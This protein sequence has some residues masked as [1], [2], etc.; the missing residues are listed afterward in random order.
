MALIDTNATTETKALY[1]QLQNSQGNYIYFGQD[2]FWEH[3][4]TTNSNNIYNQIESYKITGKVPYLLEITWN[5]ASVNALV[6]AKTH[7]RNGGFI[8]VAWNYANPVT[9]GTSHDKTG[10]PVLNILPGGTHRVN[11]LA[12][13][14]LLA[15]WAG[16]MKD[17]NGNLI[18]FIFRPFQEAD[19]TW[20]WWGEING[21][22]STIDAQYIALW[23]DMVTYLRDTKGVHNIIYDYSPVHYPLPYVFEDR[24]AGDNYIDIISVDAYKDDGEINDVLDYY[25]RAYD[26][27]NTRGKVFGVAEG[28]RKLNDFPLATYWTDYFNGI[29]ADSKVKN[30][31]FVQC[32]RTGITGSQDRWGPLQGST[33][34]ASFLT[35][36]QNPK[37][38][39]LRYED[40]IIDSNNIGINFYVNDDNNSF[41]V[42][43]NTLI[44]NGVDEGIHLGTGF[45]TKTATF[46]N[47]IIK[48]Q[49]TASINVPAG[50]TLDYNCYYDTVG[51][52]SFIYDGA[53]YNSLAAYQIAT[54]QD[55]H[56]IASDPLL[57]ADYKLKAGSPCINA[58]TPVG[59]LDTYFGGKRYY[60]KAPDIGAD[61][62]D[63]DA[64]KQYRI[65]HWQKCANFEILNNRNREQIK[66]SRRMNQP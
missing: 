56:S 27:A 9:G 32:W 54:G 60:G 2:E 48:T 22:G 11:H 43:H 1:T 62:W 10:D 40:T 64:V 20:A 58:G 12:T 7:Y 44:G 51:V 46:K 5:E 33:D 47:N 66:R 14:D 25:Q 36:S 19:M 65:D 39:M 30:A 34:E 29:F 41:L 42:Y 57:T 61:E 59:V 52:Y 49:G 3:T 13:L 16:N 18:P 31:A 4:S 23:Q 53:T 63:G 17:D 8:M 37:I 35:M 26:Q 38:R 24:Y 28:M 15:T 45:A 55:L 21:G 50:T 6:Q